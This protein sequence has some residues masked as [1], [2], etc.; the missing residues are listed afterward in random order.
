MAEVK[1]WWDGNR[2]IEGELFIHPEYQGH[3]GIGIP[4]VLALLKT[5]REKYNCVVVESITFKDGYQLPMYHK[6]GI[7]PDPELCFITGNIETILKRLEKY[8]RK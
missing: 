5:A 6:I 8:N 3:I 2:L 1:P 4:L 7:D